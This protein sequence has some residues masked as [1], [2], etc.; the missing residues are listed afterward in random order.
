[1]MLGFSPIGQQQQ[2][3]QTADTIS[4]MLDAVI[5]KAQHEAIMAMEGR[6]VDL[7]EANNRE[8]ERRRTAEMYLSA[9]INS[10]FWKA[11]ME[12]AEANTDYAGPSGADVIDWLSII[13]PEIEAHLDSLKRINIPKPET[14]DVGEV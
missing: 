13:F 10:E 8:V 2:S 4:F 5:E 11:S 14:K 3:N 12:A 9:L 1:M 7:V 6:V